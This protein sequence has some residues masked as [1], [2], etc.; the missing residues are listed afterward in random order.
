[1][2]ILQNYIEISDPDQ[3]RILINR[4]DVT[5]FIKFLYLFF[6]KKMQ[7]ITIM[8]YNIYRTFAMCQALFCLCLYIY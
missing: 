1:M 7:T 5:L 8:M 2:I 4:K 6:F 3:E